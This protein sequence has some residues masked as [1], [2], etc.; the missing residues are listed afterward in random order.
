[1]PA[2]IHNS[3]AFLSL[4]IY[5]PSSSPNTVLRGAKH[6]VILLLVL[7]VLKEFFFL[8]LDGGGVGVGEENDRFFNG[9]EVFGT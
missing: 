2:T 9:K 3:A 5:P 8:L 7:Y 6:D 4:F 1:V